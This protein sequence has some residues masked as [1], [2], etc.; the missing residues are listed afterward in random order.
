MPVQT[1]SMTKKANEQSAPPA[2]KKPRRRFIH[3]S[4]ELYCIED[5]NVYEIIE[6]TRIPRHDGFVGILNGSLRNGYR[7]NTDAQPKL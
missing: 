7:I 4:G 2:P 1:R 3:I 5:G 6:G